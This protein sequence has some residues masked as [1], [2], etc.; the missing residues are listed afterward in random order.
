MLCLIIFLS[1]KGVDFD[2]LLDGKTVKKDSTEEQ[3]GNKRSSAII[4]MISQLLL[5]E[6]F[7]KAKSITVAVL[8]LYERYVPCFLGYYSIK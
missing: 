8:A 4:E 6:N 5:M 1:H 2:G 3:Q 7:L